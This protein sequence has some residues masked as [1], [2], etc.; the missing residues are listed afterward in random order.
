MGS[1]E[2]PPSEPPEEKLG[3]RRASAVQSAVEFLKPQK[4]A[5]ALGEASLKGKGHFRLQRALEPHSSRDTC[6]Q[7]SLPGASWASKLEAAPAFGLHPH[8]GD[9]N[10]AM[11]QVDGLRITS[12]FQ[13]H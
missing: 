4:R 2:R 7:A 13:P 5:W 8:G 12:S 11:D 3:H 1:T 6:P 10:L 9:P